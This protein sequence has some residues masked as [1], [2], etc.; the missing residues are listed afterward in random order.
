MTLRDRE[1]PAKVR[2]RR[3]RQAARLAAPFEW[4]STANA[5]E[6]AV[7]RRIRDEVRAHVLAFGQRRARAI[8]SAKW[9]ADDAA[10]R[11]GVHPL[12]LDCAVAPAQ[13]IAAAGRAPRRAL[14]S[15]ARRS[16]NV[17]RRRRATAPRRPAAVG[18]GGSDDDDGA[19][20]GAPAP[21]RTPARSLRRK[22]KGPS[23]AEHTT[24]AEVRRV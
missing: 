23:Q 17:G 3:E 21:Y 20:A 10:V 19:G 4:E 9:R 1:I 14:R 12:E 11:R 15:R 16:P 24:D 13:A 2:A 5:T 8:L 18:G 7:A 6:R 22:T